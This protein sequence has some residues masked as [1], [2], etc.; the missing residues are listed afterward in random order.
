[1]RSTAKSG[2]KALATRAWTD[3]NPDRLKYQ[4]IF[5]SHET[6]EQGDALEARKFIEED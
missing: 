3:L 4:M 1:M 5:A 6:I 2:A